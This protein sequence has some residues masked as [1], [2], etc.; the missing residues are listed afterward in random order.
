MK[1]TDIQQ[2]LSGGDRRSVGKSEEVVAEV[3]AD[4]RLFGALFD[5][6][7]ADDPLVRMRAA[8]AVEKITAL[9]P[10]FLQPF[11]AKLIK[12]VAKIDQQEVRWHVAQLLTRLDLNGSER[13][14]VASIINGY[15]NDKSS[16]VRTYSMQ[17]LAELAIQD[18]ALKPVIVRQLEKLTE[19]GSPA[20]Q[21]R[22][23][24]LLAKL[25]G[26]PVGVPIHQREGRAT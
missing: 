14:T 19:E 25:K 16:I 20:M 13:K 1:R 12:R 2:K 17:A 8:D 7:L 4:A 5:C 26:D 6:M 22:G 9:R 21:S 15:L 11:K 3:L 10:D 24:K 18:A 23:R